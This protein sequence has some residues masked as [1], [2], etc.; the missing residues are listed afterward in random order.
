MLTSATRIGPD[1]PYPDRLRAGVASAWEIL[2]RKIGG[3]ETEITRE[4]SLQLH[5]A[6]TLQH[7]LPLVAFRPG[8]RAT[9]KL[10]H[11][12]GTQRKRREI[13]VF[14]DGVDGFGVHTRI[15]IEMKCYRK[16]AASGGNRGATDIFM[17]DVYE[18]LAALESYCEDGIADVG[19]AFVMN[20]HPYFVQPSRKKGKCWT[21]D[22]SDGTIVEPGVRLEAPIGGHDVCI[23]LKRGYHFSWMQ[24]GGFYF[25]ELQGEHR[26]A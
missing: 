17:K 21:Y 26:L 10:E 13:D 2:A 22:I 18:D 16:I 14:I 24:I 9:I 25:A 6:A 4:A 12:P 5:F 7:V 15:A 23:H 20:D 11:D 3:G 8:E 19:V 1:H